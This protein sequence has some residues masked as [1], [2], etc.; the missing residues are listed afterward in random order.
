MAFIAVDEQSK[1]LLGV[2]AVILLSQQFW[3]VS[4][5]QVATAIAG[6]AIGPAVNGITL[7][8]VCQGGFDPKAG[9]GS[10][11]N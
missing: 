1:K 10:P 2:S 9:R 11:A 8:I 7:G 4:V 6:A 5:S 3:L